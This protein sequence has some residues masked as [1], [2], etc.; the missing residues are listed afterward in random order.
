[1]WRRRASAEPGRP[2]GVPATIE[3]D[4]EEDGDGRLAL[5]WRPYAASLV[6]LFG[7]GI[8]I[9]LTLTHY[10]KVVSLVCSNTGSINC[11]AVTT[12]PQSVVFGIPVAV[13][14]LA[15]FVPMLV[16]CLPWAWRSPWRLLAPARLAGVVTG[17]GFVAYL[18][19]A[20]LFEIKKICLWCTGVHVLTFILFVIV[21]TGWWDA[22]ASWYAAEDRDEP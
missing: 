15:F 17:I 22:T 3:P 9:Y 14:G 11:E 2:G 1:M 5:S 16:L 21:V 4:D 7:L 10:T 13:L 19:Y 6:C 20:E 18:L 12:S 8:A